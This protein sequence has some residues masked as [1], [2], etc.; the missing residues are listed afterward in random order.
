MVSSLLRRWGRDT[1][2]LHVEDARVRLH[3]SCR[4]RQQLIYCSFSSS[5]LHSYS[6]MVLNRLQPKHISA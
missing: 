4:I 2:V 3:R 1:E 5:R 6:I